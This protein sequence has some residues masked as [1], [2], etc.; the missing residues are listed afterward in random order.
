MQR[1]RDIGIGSYNDFREICGLKRAYKWEDF[2]DTIAVHTINK[3]RQYYQDPDDLDLYAGGIAEEHVKDSMLGPVFWC[4]AGY[5]F[6][7]WKWGDRFFYTLGG[8]PSS[9]TLHQLDEIRKMSIAAV[10]CM[11][12]TV[13][14]VPAM[15]FR[16]HH[17]HTNPLESCYNHIAIP[18]INF[19]AFSAGY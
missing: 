11:T 2:Y 9:F 8:M 15:S 7:H 12:S 1:G 5:Q 16:T 19:A 4:I 10:I 14:H 13:K 17:N 3:F 6:Q 18:R